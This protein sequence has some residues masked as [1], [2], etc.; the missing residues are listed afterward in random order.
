MTTTSESGARTALTPRGEAT[1]TRLIEAAEGVFGEF[2]FD[3]ASVAEITRRSGVSQGTFYLYFT[4]K[5]KIF[6][7]LVDQFGR[8]LRRWVSEA[9]AEC[10]TRSDIER[11]GFEA[12]FEFVEMHPALYRIVRQAEFVDPDAFRR[13]YE[14]FAEGY[15]QGL[16][17]AVASGEVSDLD[18]E[19]VAWCLMGM[20]DLIGVNWL[21]LK[22]GEVP[23]TVLDTVMELLHR[24]L[25]KK[26]E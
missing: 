15:I 7:E 5:K 11:R 26:R 22:D 23:S 13:Y 1:R 16:D 3:R 6:S 19:V 8:E 24:G 21:L 14:T 4:S 2:G 20:G 9:I 18:T 25:F 17:K 10:D 12:F